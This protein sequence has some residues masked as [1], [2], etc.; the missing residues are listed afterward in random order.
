MCASSVFLTLLHY[1]IFS[2]FV[3]SLQSSPRG[4]LTDCG[5]V[6]PMVILVGRDRGAGAVLN[7]LLMCIGNNQ[8]I[9]SRMS[10]GP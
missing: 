8:G 5:G 4:D 1:L 6:E 3:E 2:Y 7:N 10:S 9:G